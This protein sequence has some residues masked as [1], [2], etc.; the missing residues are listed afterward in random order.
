MNQIQGGIVESQAGSEPLQQTEEIKPKSFFSRLGGVYFSPEA[1][2]KEIGTSPRVWMP[3]IALVIISM[4]SGFYLSKKIDLGALQS[5]QME[6]AVAQGRMTQ[7]Q[8]DQATSMVSKAGPVILVVGSAASTLF[9]ALLIA[10]VFK[11]ISV[12]ITAENRFKA[13]FVV[14]AYAMIAVSI[15]QT[16]L[17]IA[18]LT[19]KNPADLSGTNMSSII[20]S[21]LGSM[22]SALF[23]DDALPKFLM[24]LAGWADIFAIWYL[25]LL[26][27]GYAAVSRK[28]KTSRVA[29]WL[30]SIYVVIAL[31]GSAISS[32][33]S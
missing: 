25:A 28:L 24:K 2:F 26:S 13:V 7:A 23:G 27:I 31:I 1:T 3:I 15:V 8:A 21:N 18:I 14:T 11:L 32:L 4:L 10:A 30:V 9:F 22:V 6:Q 33:M 19:F 16:I 5:A 29:T 17:L 20:A 12:L